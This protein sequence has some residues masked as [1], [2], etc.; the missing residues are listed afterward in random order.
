MVVS[1]VYDVSG[2]RVVSGLAGID[3]RADA[4]GIAPFTSFAGSRGARCGFGLG[5]GAGSS[6]ARAAR[7]AESAV[8]ESFRGGVAVSVGSVSCEVASGGPFRG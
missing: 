3:W 1:R 2:R 5:G 8:S 4:G 7:A 6:D